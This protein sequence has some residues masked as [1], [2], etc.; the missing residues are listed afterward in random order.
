MSRL[1]A[2]MFFVGRSGKRMAVTVVGLALVLAGLAGVVLPLLP[3]PVL[4]IAGLAVL[5][6]EYVWARRAL[7]TAR[8]KAYRA[9]ARAKERRQ[10][11]RDTSPDG[12]PGPTGPPPQDGGP[13][14]WR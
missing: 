1:W 13:S 7:E 5:A 8:R 14:T 9:R 11:R 6:T 3:G 10:R 4:I 12:T 2:V